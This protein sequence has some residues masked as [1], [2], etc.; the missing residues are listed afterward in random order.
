MTIRDKHDLHSII[1]QIVKCFP[2]IFMDYS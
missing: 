1:Q 2:V